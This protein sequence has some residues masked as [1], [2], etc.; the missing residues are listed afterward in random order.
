[1]TITQDAPFGP[2]FAAV[3]GSGSDDGLS[4]RGLDRRVIHAL[5]VP[6]DAN[7]F[8][9]VLQFGL[10]QPLEDALRFP[11]PKSGRRPCWMRPIL[12]ATHSI[13]CLFAAHR[14]S[15]QTSVDHQRRVVLLWSV[16]DV[17]ESKGGLA[18]TIRR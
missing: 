14:Q 7:Q 12:V 16:E 2:L 13:G 8:V 15:R 9:V 6:R 17:A 11:L 4:E 10:P 1:M 18:P 5:P 3:G